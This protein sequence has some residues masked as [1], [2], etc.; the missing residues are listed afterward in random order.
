MEVAAWPSA[1]AD[2]G[3]GVVWTSAVGPAEI[4]SQ[5]DETLRQSAASPKGL[6]QHRR[7]GAIF[8]CR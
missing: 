1:A 3:G 8:N 6:R 2:G 7:G 5:L 4:F